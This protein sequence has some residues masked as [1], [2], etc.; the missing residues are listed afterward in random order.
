MRAITAFIC[1]ALVAGCAMEPPPPVATGS[2]LPTTARVAGV[3]FHPQTGFRC[4]PAAMAQVMA[5]AGVPV[6]PEGMAD[7]F[8]RPADDPRPL[9]TDVAHRYGR[10]A[11]P[12]VG[13]EAMMGELAAGHPVLILQNLGVRS[14]PMWHCIVAVGYDRVRGE[15]LVNSGG[16]EGKAMSVRLFERLWSDSGQWGLLVLKPGDLPATADHRSYLQAARALEESG[17][18]WEAVLA[19]DGALARWPAEAEA[20][21]GLGS[22]LHLLG[23]PQG[24]ADAYRAAA[25]LADDPAP[26]LDRLALVLAELGRRDEAVAAAR[27]AVALGGPRKAS[28]ER[29]LKDVMD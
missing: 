14:Q 3:P 21:M 6:P 16:E 18:H 9:L 7:L 5:T 19:Y 1:T 29:T 12:V 8:A 17:R 2:G 28:H 13:V 26:A 27:E 20:L 15:V 25:A 11:Y 22:S 24:A 4:G 10:L 23:D